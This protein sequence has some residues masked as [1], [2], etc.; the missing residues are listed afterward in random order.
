M[1]HNNKI[2]KLGR[3]SA[4]RKATLSALSSALLRHKRI[5][6]TVT[7]AKALRVYVEPVIT[8]SKDDKTSNRR[9]A[10]RRLRSKDAVKEL[11]NVIAEAVA[12]RNGGYTRVVKIGKRPG[13]GTEMA[14]IELVDFNTTGAEPTKAKVSRRRRTRRGG[15]KPSATSETA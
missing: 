2:S 5:K 14:I 1:R 6:T 7:K 11:F 4:H 8:R 9:Q 13:D 3:T 12:E 15:A 10:F